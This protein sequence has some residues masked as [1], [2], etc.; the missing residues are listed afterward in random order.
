MTDA[1]CVLTVSVLSIALFNEPIQNSPSRKLRY[2]QYSAR[3]PHYTIA[4]C[5]SKVLEVL[6]FVFV[7]NGL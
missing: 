6:K 5:A 3:E 4:S 7:N 2:A 1:V